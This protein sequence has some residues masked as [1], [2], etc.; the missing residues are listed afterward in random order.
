MAASGLVSR[1]WARAPF[2]GAFISLALSAAL[3]A[4]TIFA[5]QSGATESDPEDAIFG[6]GWGMTLALDGTGF[7]NDVIKYALTGVQRGQRY[8]PL[9]YK[10]AKVEFAAHG[11]SCLY[12]SSIPHLLNGAEIETA[13]DYVETLPLIFVESHI[14]SRPGTEALQD[15]TL[16][17]GKTIAYANGSALPNILGQFDPIFIPTTD[18]TT[19]AR[20]LSAG[21]VDFMSGSLPDNIFVFEALG[22]PLP[23]YNPDLSILKVGIG[24]VCHRTPENEAFVGVVNALLENQLVRTGMKELF[25]NAGVA[26]RFFPEPPQRDE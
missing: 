26:P 3:G 20:M 12:P 11:R 25:E 21:R 23:A 1:I 18:E 16:L 7:Y 4:A 17:A 19:K 10:R 6:T 5:P 24:I 9:P 15:F 2:G 22:E 13:H 14:F 8:M